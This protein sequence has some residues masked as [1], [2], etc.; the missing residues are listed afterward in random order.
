M[1]IIIIVVCAMMMVSCASKA[2]MVKSEVLDAEKGQSVSSKT[3]VQRVE[4]SIPGLTVGK[5]FGIDRSLV[6][7][8][9]RR[10]KINRRVEG[11]MRL[12][13]N[14]G[15]F[16]EVTFMFSSGERLYNRFRRQIN[17]TDSKNVTNKIEYL[18]FSFRKQLTK[19]SYEE[20]QK[21]FASVVGFVAEELGCELQCPAISDPLSFSKDENIGR[22][23]YFRDWTEVMCRVFLAKNLSVCVSGEEPTFL[24][25]GTK[26][27]H[28]KPGV[29]KLSFYYDYSRNSETIAIQDSK[30]KVEKDAISIDLGCDMSKSFE[31]YVLGVL[32]YNGGYNGRRVIRSKFE[33]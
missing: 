5:I 23:S 4:C 9:M 7:D 26:T 11:N 24:M 15:I 13:R 21:A 28:Y 3:N 32:S 12:D 1:K 2:H 30:D 29:I 6:E 27:F 33:K 8:I 16:D 17:Q 22:N 19:G 10:K 14:F 25:R 31:S 20:F 18:Q